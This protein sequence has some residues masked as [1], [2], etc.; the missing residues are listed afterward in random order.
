M[1]KT[2]IDTS[3]SADQLR[4]VIE[5]IES[6]EEQKAAIG[7]DIREVF[8]E[9]KGAGFDSKAIRQIIKLRKMEAHVREEQET[10]LETYMRALNMTPQFE[11]DEDAA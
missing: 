4:S 3:L 7:A 8:A 9:S 6:L 11:D 2:M 1:P 10:I 5:R